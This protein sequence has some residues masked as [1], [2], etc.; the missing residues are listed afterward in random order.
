MFLW[1]RPAGDLAS[2]LE[3]PDQL[4]LLLHLLQVEARPYVHGAGRREPPTATM[5]S[6][7]ALGVWGIRSN[8]LSRPGRPYCSSKTWGSL[9]GNRVSKTRIPNFW[10]AGIV[11]TS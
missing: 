7:P 10:E 8:Q 4:G 2:E 11:K 3:R 5:P 6:P 9:P 1:G